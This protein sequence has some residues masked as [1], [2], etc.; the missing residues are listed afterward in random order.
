MPLE[1]AMQANKITAPN[2]E[3]RSQFPV[4]LDQSRQPMK[5]IQF[6]THHQVPL[7]DLKQALRPLFLTM[8]VLAF[9]SQSPAQIILSNRNS[10]AVIDPTSSAGLQHWDIQGLNQLHQQ[11][12]WYRVGN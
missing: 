8:F 7:R 5:T 4:G 6:T 9:T 12:F 3:W 2:A 11:W 1:D 10:Q